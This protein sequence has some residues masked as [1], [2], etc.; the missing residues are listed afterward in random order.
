MICKAMTL[1]TDCENFDRCVLVKDILGSDNIYVEDT[2]TS[3]KKK[4]TNFEKIKS[5]TV[6]EMA[7]MLV[8]STPILAL[9]LCGNYVTNVKQSIIDWLESECEV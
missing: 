6:D 1:C 3:I 8:E 5:M 2:K 7:N 4:P 9:K